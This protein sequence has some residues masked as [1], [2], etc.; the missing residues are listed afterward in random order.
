MNINELALEASRLHS[1]CIT[2]LDEWMSKVEGCL[3]TNYSWDDVHVNIWEKPDWLI[4]YG[5]V[6][7]HIHL[8]GV[9]YD[10]MYTDSYDSICDRSVSLYI[11]D[12]WLDA[13]IEDVCKDIVYLSS[14]KYNEE[15]IQSIKELQKK[16]EELNLK[17]VRQTDE[18][19]Y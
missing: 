18:D 6:D 10:F 13:T 4:E 9:R 11:Y 15:R 16:A 3:R 12:K 2:Q 5:D 7:Y 14:R 17:V 8:D 1:E 19:Y